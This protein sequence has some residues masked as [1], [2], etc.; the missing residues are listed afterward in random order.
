MAVQLLES[1]APLPEGVEAFLQKR[2]TVRSFAAKEYLLHAGDNS[3]R[4]SFVA[5]GLVRIFSDTPSKLGASDKEVC[6]WFLM[7]GDVAISVESFF[8]QTVSEEYIQAL[9]PTVT[10]SLS[11]D[12]LADVYKR[13]PTFNYHGRILTQRYYVQAV[14]QLKALR[15]KRADDSYKYLAEQFPKILQR[16]PS[17][18]LASYLGVN[19]TY[20]ST[21]RSRN[22]I[23]P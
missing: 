5:S 18:Y 23:G 20:L 15:Y 3:D 2:L 1:I 11:R 4:L 6:N 13:F 7:E 19:E 9:E 16:V 8:E 22:L 12:E 21:L 10:V 17:R 14:R